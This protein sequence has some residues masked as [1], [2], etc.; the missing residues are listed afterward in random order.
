[1]DAYS[2]ASLR[3]R[4][5]FASSLPIHGF[6]YKCPRTHSTHAPTPR[7]GR[8][9]AQACRAA[10]A[11]HLPKPGAGGRDGQA[12]LS[13]PLC[14]TQQQQP[15]APLHH[16]AYG[17][18]PPYPER[19]WGPLF[20]GHPVPSRRDSPAILQVCLSECCIPSLAA[21]DAPPSF[22]PGLIIPLPTLTQ[23]H[24]RQT[25][26]SN[27]LLLSLLRLLILVITS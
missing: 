26:T 12:A 2:L 25:I 15:H 13:S 4:R 8:G 18:P 6:L 5:A 24:W 27:S 20:F 16:H 9:L 11:R 7:T 1:M 17:R 10:S 22:L 19:L 21:D 23:Q 3:R 14:S